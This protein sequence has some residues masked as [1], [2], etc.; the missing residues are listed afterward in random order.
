MIGDPAWQGFHP[1]PSVPGVNTPEQEA[2]SPE[3][4]IVTVGG[5]A[6][7]FECDRP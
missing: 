2:S 6:T 1:H 5:R 3:P 4:I 7:L